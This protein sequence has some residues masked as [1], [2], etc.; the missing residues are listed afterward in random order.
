VNREATKVTKHYS[1]IFV[2]FVLRGLQARQLAQC[3]RTGAAKARQ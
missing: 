2:F 1:L 3:I